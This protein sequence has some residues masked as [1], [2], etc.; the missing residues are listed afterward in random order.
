MAMISRTNKRLDDNDSKDFRYYVLFFE[1]LFQLKRG[2]TK[3]PDGT[4]WASFRFAQ[5]HK[6]LRD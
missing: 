5:V 2:V 3:I 4:G 6:W 1:L